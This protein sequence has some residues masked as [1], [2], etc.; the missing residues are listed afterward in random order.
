MHALKISPSLDVSIYGTLPPLVKT[1]LREDTLALP[2]I[3]EG[4]KRQNS[5]G[6]PIMAI[7]GS[8]KRVNHKGQISNPTLPKF[9]EGAE[10]RVRRHDDVGSYQGLLKSEHP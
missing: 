5:L 10:G 8:D 9:E 3:G 6:K 7:I 2:K 4:Q 1:W